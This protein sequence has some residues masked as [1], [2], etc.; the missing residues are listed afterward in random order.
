MYYQ[1]ETAS[2]G[3]GYFMRLKYFSVTTRAKEPEPEAIAQLTSGV[4][5]QKLGVV[6]QT[7]FIATKPSEASS[8][9]GSSRRS[10]IESQAR[11][12]LY[13]SPRFPHAGSLEQMNHFDDLRR[14]LNRSSSSLAVNDD[15]ERT[16]SVSSARPSSIMPPP[17]DR[18]ENRPQSPTDSVVSSTIDVP[19]LRPRPHLHI[20][21]TDNQ[22]A[23]AAV[24][25]VKA[26]ATGLLEAPS[27]SRLGV[28]EEDMI[29][30][31]RSSPISNVGTVRADHRSMQSA[32]HFSMTFGEYE[33][34]WLRKIRFNLFAVQNLEM[35][36]L[37]PSSCS[38]TMRTRVKQC[39]ILGRRSMK[40]P[41]VDETPLDKTHSR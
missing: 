29:L 36:A 3:D 34:Y 37:M 18:P 24:G 35:W 21:S 6:P 38:S 32:K 4:E 13:S 25:P 30:S 26:N 39:K 23:P 17:P 19:S 9:A 41:F 5:L 15:H 33:R 31:G 12:G 22:K 11:H 27:I 1:G 14:P 16:T 8:K 7:I 40:H 28:G 10:T 2:E 20:G